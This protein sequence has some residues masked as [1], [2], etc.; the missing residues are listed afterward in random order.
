MGQGWAS[1]LA[2]LVLATLVVTASCGA[3]WGG[4]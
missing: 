1:W 4:A 2:Y 3:L